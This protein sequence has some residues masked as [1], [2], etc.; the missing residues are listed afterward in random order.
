MRAQ[1]SAVNAVY[2]ARLGQ[3]AFK[4]RRVNFDVAENSSGAPGLSDTSRRS[5]TDP[6][7]ASMSEYAQ[8]YDDPILVPLAPAPLGLPTITHVLAYEHDKHNS[9]AKDPRD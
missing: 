9:K 4:V 7:P 2:L 6:P 1:L 3:V 5:V 8:S